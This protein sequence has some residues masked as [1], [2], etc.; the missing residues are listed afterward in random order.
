MFGY[1][2]GATSSIQTQI[3]NANTAIS[4]VAF[5]TSDISWAVGLPNKT[6]IAN[7]YSTSVLTFSSSLNNISPT[8]FGYLSG[9]SSGIQ[10]Q[11]N[12]ASTAII[13]A[14]NAKT[15]DISWIAG[16]VNRLDIRNAYST[17]T[18]TFSKKF[19]YYF[20]NNV[21]LFKWINI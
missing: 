14:L 10:D 19:K 6:T 7:A 15:I 20:N 17:H 12:T 21:S 4:N 16:A 3:S 2:S 8:V 9:V 1:L 13:A 18:L 11:L 5:K